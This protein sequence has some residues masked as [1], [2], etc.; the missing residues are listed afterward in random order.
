MDNKLR[1]Y[2]LDYGKIIAASFL[3]LHHYQQVFDC[4][5]FGINFYGGRFVFGYFVEFFFIISG[6]L[7]LYADINKINLHRGG[8]RDLYI[9]Y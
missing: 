8:Y 2:G 9:N 5:F 1:I 7:T 4:K 3:V 6:F